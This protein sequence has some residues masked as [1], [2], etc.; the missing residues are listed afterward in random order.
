MKLAGIFLLVLAVAGNTAATAQT[1]DLLG[2]YFDETGDVYCLE[3]VPP[4]TPFAMFAVL[5]DPSVPAIAGFEFGMETPSDLFLLSAQPMCNLFWDPIEN[6]PYV[7]GCGSAVP[8]GEATVLVHF[9][10]MAMAAS[11]GPV[12]FLVTGSQYP[13]LPG[14]G[15]ALLLP[16]NTL[17]PLAVRGGAEGPTATLFEECVVASKPGTWDGVK[18]LYR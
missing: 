8:V 3:W 4:F 15:P 11:P 18:S 5:T 12:H 6:P 17:L 2:V 14:G 7:V 1:A 9:R 16:D 13:S 10:F